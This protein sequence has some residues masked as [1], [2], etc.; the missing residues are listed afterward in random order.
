MPATFLQVEQLFR[1]QQARGAFPG[2]QLVVRRDGQVLCDV[3]VGWA[4]PTARGW[5]SKIW[6]TTPRALPQTP[7]RL[8]A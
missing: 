8:A 5:C 3:A 1:E 2:G 6:A 4:R 7:H